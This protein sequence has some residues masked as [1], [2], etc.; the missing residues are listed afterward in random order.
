MNCELIKK[1]NVDR[2]IDEKKKEKKG[3]AGDKRV[4]KT[5]KS[6]AVALLRSR[7]VVKQSIQ[8]S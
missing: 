8:G 2:M 6:V 3:F 7:M 5:K 1:D 4:A